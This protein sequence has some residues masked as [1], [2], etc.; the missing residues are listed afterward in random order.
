MVIFE[1]DSRK[2]VA[3]IKKH[4]VD[5]ADAVGIF[6]DVRAI[7]IEDADA[8]GEQRFCSIGLDFTMKLLVVVYTYRHEETIRIIAARKATGKERAAYE[9]GI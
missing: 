3:N 2:A 1:W 8:E 6:E 7:V 9:S 4:G 5:F